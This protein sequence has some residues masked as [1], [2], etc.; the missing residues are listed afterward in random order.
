MLHHNMLAFTLLPAGAALSALLCQRS[1]GLCIECTMPD[2]LAQGSGN[3]GS[4]Q[5][6]VRVGSYAADRSYG[7]FFFGGGPP[8]NNDTAVFS[9]WNV[10]FAFT[11]GEQGLRLVA[12][13]VGCTS[14]GATLGRT[15]RTWSYA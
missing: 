14:A 1:S 9:Q 6:H 11:A 4:V 3:C 7:Q 5:A 2:G 10:S 12:T 8:N 15:A 13:P